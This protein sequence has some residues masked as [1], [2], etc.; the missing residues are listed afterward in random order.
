[1][2]AIS[3][4]KISLEYRH[5]PL[6][7]NTNFNHLSTT[8]RITQ[9]STKVYTFYCISIWWQ[10][11]ERLFQCEQFGW[12]DEVRWGLTGQC[13]GHVCSQVI[14]GETIFNWCAIERG[15]VSSC[16]IVRG[17]ADSRASTLTDYRVQ[18]LIFVHGRVHFRSFSCMLIFVVT[19]FVFKI[20]LF[21]FILIKI[22]ISFY[23]LG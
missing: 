5:S 11:G 3:L 2:L 22:Y 21:K 7:L 1:M 8:M 14:T 19:E 17:R 15:W 4:K 23:N 12:P 6:K 10:I 18:V 13:L 16:T 9:F 20:K